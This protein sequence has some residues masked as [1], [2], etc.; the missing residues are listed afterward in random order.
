MRWVL[1]ILAVFLCALGWY[2]FQAGPARSPWESSTEPQTKAERLPE[3][4]DLESNA[5][6]S[7]AR[8]AQELASAEPADRP[9]ADPATITVQGRVLDSARRALAQ[10]AIHAS[11]E[12]RA[13]SAAELEHSN[14]SGDL[15]G[16]RLALSDEQGRF[17]FAYAPQGALG[18]L[19]LELELRLEGYVPQRVLLRAADGH[20]LD[21]QEILLYR[22]ARLEGLVLE[23]GAVPA[24]KVEVLAFGET[25]ARHSALSDAQGRFALEQLA[26]GTWRIEARH[27]D[28]RSSSARSLTL[29]EGERASGLELVLEALDDPLSISGTLSTSD[30]QPAVGARLGYEQASASMVQNGSIAVGE[31]GRFRERFEQAQPIELRATHWRADGVQEILLPQRVQPGTHQLPLRMQPA[32]NLRLRV[33]LPNGQPCEQ[34]ALSITTHGA[35]STRTESEQPLLDRPA[36]LATFLDCGGPMSLTVQAP[37]FAPQS[38]G[39]FDPATQAEWQLQLEALRGLHGVVVHAGQAIAGAR[40]RLAR[41]LGEN[42][43]VIED[44]LRALVAPQGETMVTTNAQGEFTMYPESAGAWHLV[45]EAHGY[46]RRASAA[47]DYDPRAVRE[48]VVIE[49]GRGGALEGRVLSSAGQPRSARWVFA[50]N[51]IP[52]AR[53]VQSDAQGRFVFEG[54]DEGSYSLSTRTHAPQSQGTMWSEG[55]RSVPAL[56]MHCQ[57]R[58]GQRTQ[59]DLI[60]PEPAIVLLEIS[61]ALLERCSQWE[62]HAQ[63]LASESSSYGASFQGH[64]DSSGRSMRFELPEPG[65]F[66]IALR[67][68]V[69]CHF[70]YNGQASAGTTRLSL[71]VEGSPLIVAPKSGSSLPASLYASSR[72]GEGWSAIAME[73]PNERGEIEFGF[74]PQGPYELQAPDGAQ[75]SFVHTGASALRIEW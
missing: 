72:W 56:R 67:M 58:E 37:G 18:W 16:Q 36:G 69:L 32:R 1:A 6:T 8:A 14:A 62:A 31:G 54:L 48:P 34:Y 39:P 50:N 3:A 43:L 49:L 5:A 70:Q 17:S 64:F 59:Y 52:P 35:H 19:Q 33:L 25:R 51:G 7:P 15:R 10:V 73:G 55:G 27:R 2:L 38:L 9:L 12:T 68:G 74:W 71:S 45:I 65:A 28:G 75:R 29:V 41:A 47:I 53:A 26:P 60:E 4:L 30:G 63:C 13:A 57:V 40:V 66:E 61:A 20:N 24:S 42:A 11:R 44:G 21:A 23:Q 46:A 22:V